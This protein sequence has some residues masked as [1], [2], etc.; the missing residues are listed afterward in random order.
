MIAALLEFPIRGYS[1]KQVSTSYVGVLEFMFNGDCQMENS[2]ALAKSLL[3][4]NSLAEI[5]HVKSFL[6]Y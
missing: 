5:E 4:E 3:V 2:D 1:T 6:D